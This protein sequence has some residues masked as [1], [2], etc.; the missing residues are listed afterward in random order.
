MAEDPVV[1]MGAGRSLFRVGD[2]VELAQLIERIRQ[3]EQADRR[4]DGVPDAAA[5]TGFLANAGTAGHD[6]V[7][8][9]PVYNTI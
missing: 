5:C 4:S 8:K 7:W 9:L 3:R 2:L 6:V 1:T